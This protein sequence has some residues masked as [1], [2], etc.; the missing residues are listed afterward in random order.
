MRSVGLFGLV[1]ANAVCKPRRCSWLCD[2][3]IL[4]INPQEAA[5]KTTG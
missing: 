2:S 5:A 4:F 1:G 3:T